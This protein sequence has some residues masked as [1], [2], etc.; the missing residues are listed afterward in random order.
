M[1]ISRLQGSKP[2]AAPADPKIEGAA[3]QFE[4][5]LLGQILK[6]VRESASSGAL[7]GGDAASDS[8][9]GFAEEQLAQAL[10]A[11]GGIGLANL[12][13]QGFAQK[14]PTSSDSSSST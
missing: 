6:S 3:K 4:A 7:G 5:L 11:R 14:A 2:P 12:I 9:M 13:T 1:E 10:S 8:A